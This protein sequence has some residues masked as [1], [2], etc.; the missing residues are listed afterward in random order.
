M[1]CMT[2]EIMLE[3]EL[4]ER[5]NKIL[6]FLVNFLATTSVSLDLTHILQTTFSSLSLLFPIHTLHAVVWRPEG[7]EA[8]HLPVSLHIAA[9]ESSA[10][11]FL[12]RDT[13]LEQAGQ[14][15]GRTCSVERNLFLDLSA[16]KGARL[17]ASPTDGHLIFLPIATRSETI[18]VI[19]VLT[20]FNRDLGR[21]QNQ[22]LESALRH[23]ALVIR[24]IYHF[25]RLQHHADYDVLTLVHSRRHLEQR[26]EWEM[27][28]YRRYKHPLSLIMLDIDH[29]KHV[30][31]TRGHA[32][33]D[34]ILRE[35]ASLIMQTIRTSD[36]CARYGGE[37][38][39]LLLPHTDNKK[40]HNLAERLRS[41]LA[42]HTFIVDGTPLNI[43]ISLGVST[44][45]ATQPKNSD[46]LISE[47]DAAL[48]E[49]KT[50]GR[51][52]IRDYKHIQLT[53]AAVS[54]G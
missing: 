10:G 33:G 49:A 11:F 6:T 45:K 54:A 37:E 24:N 25:Q 26:M 44:L 53:F 22:A 18:G 31:D 16:Q 27:D 21:D 42:A 46:A 48:Y 17:D 19:A 5:K 15:S 28:R 20:D 4:L 12:W 47:A 41:K 13:L 43:T 51:N 30:N 7:Q 35:T 23:M 52:Q 2:R 50:R 34:A 40:A 29:F 1:F 14:L 36:Y 3:R 32:V 38:F 39:L 9:P 8:G